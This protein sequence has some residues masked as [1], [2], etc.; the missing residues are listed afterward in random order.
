[1]IG[2]DLGAHMN[3]RRS[4]DAKRRLIVPLVLAISIASA[5][6]AFTSTTLGCGTDKPHLD[7]GNGDGRIDTPVV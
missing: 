5:A 2:C 1:V 7:A 3:A 6:A 4:P